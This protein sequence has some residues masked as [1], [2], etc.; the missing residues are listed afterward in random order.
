MSKTSL[1]ILTALSIVAPDS[2]CA[3]I[4]VFLSVL[5]LILIVLF[6]WPDIRRELE[7]RTFI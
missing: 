6:R 5:T 7:K 3:G 2:E 4:S 1:P